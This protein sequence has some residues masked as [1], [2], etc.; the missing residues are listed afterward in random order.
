MLCLEWQKKNV[1]RA[2]IGERWFDNENWTTNMHIGFANSLR[3]GKPSHMLLTTLTTALT[4]AKWP[5][6]D[7]RMQDSS[8][9]T[10]KCLKHY[11]ATLSLNALHETKWHNLGL[12]CGFWQGKYTTSAITFFS[13][14]WVL[15][16]R[17]I[18]HLSTTSVEHRSLECH[19]QQT[20]LHGLFIYYLF[21]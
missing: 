10:V 18:V 3:S 14:T 7:N 12:R 13:L 15:Y 4:G 16:R 5:K 6:Y 8:N 21:F 1:D 11:S 19:F 20:V 17:K 2:K 9:T